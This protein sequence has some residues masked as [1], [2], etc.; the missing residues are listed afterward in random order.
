MLVLACELT[1][2]IYGLPVGPAAF[3]IAEALRTSAGWQQNA[4]SF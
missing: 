4:V 2:E 1:C 3:V